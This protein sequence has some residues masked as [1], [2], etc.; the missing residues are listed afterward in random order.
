MSA[1]CSKVLHLLLRLLDAVSEGAIIFLQQR[2]FGYVAGR[3]SPRFQVTYVPANWLGQSIDS[4]GVRHEGVHLASQ[5]QARQI[6][7]GQVS[8]VPT[9]SPHSL[10]R[11]A[12]WLS[13]PPNS[14]GSGTRNPGHSLPDT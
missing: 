10:H 4:L 7:Q 3:I 14:V 5:S 12:V 1:L 6:G 8:I 13:L 2:Q 9:T 11:S